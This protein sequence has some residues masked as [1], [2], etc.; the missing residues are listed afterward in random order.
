[1]SWISKLYDTYQNCESIVGK[2]EKGNDPVLMPIAHTT[3]NAHVEFSIDIEGNFIKGSSRAIKD[4]FDCI[5]I[6][7]CTENSQNRTSKPVSHPLFDKTQYLAGDYSKYG[8]EKGKESHD[9][10]IKSLKAWCNSKYSNPKACAILKYLEKSTLIEDL[11]N[12][13]LIPLDENKNVIRKWDSKELGEKQGIYCAYQLTDALDAFIRINVH[14]QNSNEEK[15]WNDQQLHNDFINYYC[16]A[17][18]DLD[19]CYVKG[20]RIPTARMSPSKIRN[21]GDKAKIISA[22]DS[23]GYTYRGRFADD[24]QAYSIGYETTQKA[25]NTLKWLISKQGFRNGDQVYVVWGTNNE[26]IPPLEYNSE[27]IFNL[28]TDDESQEPFVHT[29]YAIKVKKMLA[30]YKQKLTDR[31]EVVILGLDSATTGRL[32]LTHYEELSGSTYLERLENW[33]NTCSWQ[34]SYIKNKNGE[35]ISCT[36]TPSPLE[37]IFSVYGSKITDKLK[38]SA[39]QRFMPCILD[40]KPIPIDFVKSA[41]SRASNPNI[42]DNKSA[43]FNYDYRKTLE[44]AC[45]LIKKYY[46][47][48]NYSDRSEYTLALDKNNKSRSY[49]FG[50]I[51]AYYHYIEYCA[52]KSNN[53]DRTTNA[54]RLQSAYSRK[55]K[56]TL[57]ILDDKVNPYIVRMGNKLNKTSSELQEILSELD[58]N[59]CEKMTNEPLDATY[60]LGYSSQ[61]NELF[62]KTNKGE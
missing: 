1:M 45:A 9:A 35:S 49:L 26:D 56:Q 41:A 7:P 58:G 62:N 48:K 43:R 47:D 33:F 25:H 37:I 24:K 22:N 23:S 27:D 15:T 20:D 8:G 17:M 19:I 34:L 16:G 52:L 57:R 10:Y 5:T 46:N 40:G 29:E 50:R 39:I 61:L 14:T 59:N 55:P 38:K 12:D 54:M 13:N 30:G 42:F 21:T 18:N 51:L 44:V 31:S 4:K 32:S 60:I 11:I 36:A 6:I 53:A 3:Q 2:I 28:I